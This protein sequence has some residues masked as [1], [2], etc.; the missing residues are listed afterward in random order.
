MNMNPRQEY[1]RPQMVRQDW[2]NLNGEWEFEIDNGNSGL[3]RKMYEKDHL[4]G[5]IIVPFCPESEL[6]GVNNKDFMARVWYR[7][8]IEIPE[9]WKNDRVL[10]HVD[11]CDFE[12]MV[13]V[14][15]K[16]AGKHRGGYTPFC[17]D[18]TDKLEDGKG[19]IVITAEDDVRSGNQPGGKQ[20]SLYHSYGCSYTR[21]TGIWQT[22]WLEKVPQAYI[23]ETK[24]TPDIDAGMLYVEAVCNGADGMKLTAEAEYEGKPMGC[25]SATVRGKTARMA[26]SLAETHL[27]E[28]GNGRLYDLKL[29]LGDDVCQS[30]FGM[31]SI[32][33]VDGKLLLNGKVVFQRLILD[34]GFYPDGIY[35]APSDAELKNDIT[36]CMDMG[37]NGARLHE[38]IFEPRF[39]YHCDKLGYL[40]W[41]EHA[42]WGLN[43]SR[44]EAWRGFIPEWLES[45]R[46]DYNHPAIIGWCPLNETQKDQDPEFVKMLM[47]MTRAYDPTR[48]LVDAS[49]WYHTGDG[50]IVDAHCYEQDPAKFAEMIAAMGR[51]EGVG[52]HVN[53]PTVATFMSEFGGTW[54]SK[55]TNGWGYG[56]SP[57]SEEE[58]LARFKGLM[59]AL[60]DAPNMCAFCYTQLTDVEQ[61]QNGLYTYDRQP[62]FP[63]EVIK[64]IVSRKAA[65]ED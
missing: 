9:S 1:P 5:K 63:P 24:Y 52:F 53:V 39:L 56:A 19:T 65:I 17:F 37:F 3:D 21:T 2:I 34:Q 36:R 47:D 33:Y 51:G 12:S 64:P 27:W 38:K 25:G 44:P 4:E 61:E 49:G 26:I 29:T 40:V 59:D 10:L 30:Y 42:N 57:L 62:K 7:K 46:R 31:R 45:I 6:S 54:W 35:T 15:G 22:V 32:A 11:A 41:G 28:A 60:L 20:S 43:I 16:L 18:I 50:D 55:N 13:W 14:N 48:P 23:V 58:F 8:E